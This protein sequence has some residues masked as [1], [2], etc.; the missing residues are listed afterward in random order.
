MAEF[1]PPQPSGRNFVQRE[2][3]RIVDP[4]PAAPASS[5]FVD[6][7]GSAVWSINPNLP[8]ASVRTLQDIYD[9]SLARTSFTL[10]MLGHRR[11]RWRC[12]SA[13][14]ASTA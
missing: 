3:S 12:C 4:Q 10:V 2:R 8:L 1:P 7:L 9:A 13:W 11:R 5:G 14:P 6:E